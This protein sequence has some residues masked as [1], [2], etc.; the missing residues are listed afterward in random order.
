MPQ[1][2]YLTPFG[3][4]APKRATVGSV[5]T[6]ELTETGIRVECLMY[7]IES[8]KPFIVT[9][10]AKNISDV[11]RVVLELVGESAVA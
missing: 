9:G 10:T 1:N 5:R 3:D 8:R 4:G 2:E 11:K 7:E 6:S